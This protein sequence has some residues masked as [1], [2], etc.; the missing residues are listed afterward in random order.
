MFLSPVAGVPLA[1][2]VAALKYG[3]DDLGRIVTYVPYAIVTG[4]LVGVYAAWALATDVILRSSPRSRRPPPGCP[5]RPS[6]PAFP[7]PAEG[8]PP[9]QPGQV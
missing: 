7:D 6:A 9:F 3:P 2:V 1:C 4:L 8:A 5:R